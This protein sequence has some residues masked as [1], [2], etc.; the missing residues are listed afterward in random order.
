[1]SRDICV[2][3]LRPDVFEIYADVWG[4]GDNNEGKASGVREIEFEPVGEF[5]AKARLAELVVNKAYLTRLG[6][7]IPPQEITQHS[8]RDNETLPMAF[9]MKTRTPGAFI[10]R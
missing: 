6:L 1:M 7:K 5:R 4:S 2:I 8:A 10:R 9:E 3:R